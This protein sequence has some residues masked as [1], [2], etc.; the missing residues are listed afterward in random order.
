ML[1]KM[2]EEQTTQK[3]E[4]IKQEPEKELYFYK[5]WIRPSKKDGY[6]TYLIVEREGKRIKTSDYQEGDFIY[7]L[8]YHINQKHLRRIYTYEII[9]EDK[10]YDARKINEDTIWYI[11]EIYMLSLSEEVQEAIRTFYL[12]YVNY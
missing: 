9:K 11:N 7:L 3:E 1:E 8:S 10:Q 2:Q 5:N 12:Q 6:K 4:T